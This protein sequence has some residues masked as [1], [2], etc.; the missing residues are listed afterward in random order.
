M[1]DDLISRQA[2]LLKGCP[3]C[4]KELIHYSIGLSGAVATSLEARCDDCNAA[5]NIDLNRWVYIDGKPGI[6]KDAIDIWN[7]REGMGQ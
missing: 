2:T 3:F 6:F 7:C 5:F 4:G 1:M